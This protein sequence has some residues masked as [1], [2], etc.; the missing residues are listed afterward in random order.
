MPGTL[1]ITSIEFRAGSKVGE[2][3]LQVAPNNVV[4]LVGPNNSGK[5]LA[6]KEIEN[7]CGGKINSGKVINTINVDTPNDAATLQPLLETFEI[8]TPEGQVE[9]ADNIWLNQHSFENQNPI[10]QQ[11]NRAEL[12]EIVSNN[13]FNNANVKALVKFYQIRL[14]GRTR[15]SLADAKPSGDILSTPLNHLWKLFKDDVAREEVRRLTEEAFG[16]H[17]VIDPTGMLQFKIRMSS[18]AP[19]NKAEEQGLDEVSRSFHLAAQEIKEL[20]DGVQ[21]FVGLISAILSLPHKILLIDEP[22]AFLHP[23]LARRLGA[24]LARLARERD[25]SLIT[26]THSADFVMGC[27]E[28]VTNTIVVR[29]TFENNVPTAR[30]LSDVDLQEMIKNPLLRSTGTLRALFHRA[31]IVGESDSDRAFYDEINNRLLQNNRGIKDALFINAQNKQTIRKVVG[32]LRK[33]GV[34]AVAIVDLDIIR[35]PGDLTRLMVDCNVSAIHQISYETERVWLLSEL[36][37]VVGAG[38]PL[39]NGGINLLT[40]ANL[41]RANNFLSNLKQY[42][43]FLVPSGEAET[44]L[45]A[46]G[47]IGHGSEWLIDMFSKIGQTPGDANYRHPAADDVWQF[48]DSINNWIQDPNRLGI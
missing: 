6:L 27:L 7:I 21:A 24:N 43:I 26:S 32:P 45:A 36:Q 1:K 12:L 42:G 40:G 18:R 25:A 44:W 9:N 3:A 30:V 46:V 35:M 15:F 34:P 20:S 16:L 13:G 33:I 38:D 14:D 5:S 11:F 28:S 48:M 47:A 8:P 37:A 22:E 4:I 2:P 39:K 41:V 23:P 31:A 17:F 19:A 29:F 10:R